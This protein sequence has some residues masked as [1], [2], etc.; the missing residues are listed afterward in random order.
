MKENV[1]PNVQSI[2]HTKWRRKN[3]SK[4]TNQREFECPNQ[5][6]NVMMEIEQQASRKWEADS[7]TGCKMNV[8]WINMFDSGGKWNNFYACKLSAKGQKEGL[9]ERVR[10]TV[11]SFTREQLMFIVATFRVCMEM[12]TTKKCTG[13]SVVFWRIRENASCIQCLNQWKLCRA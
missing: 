4:C 7:E 3:P 8:K 11:I 10:E 13:K 1:W 6:R 9:K 5:Q 2:K 12:K